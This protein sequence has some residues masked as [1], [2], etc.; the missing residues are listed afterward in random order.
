MNIAG[1]IYNILELLCRGA[2]TGKCIEVNGRKAEIGERTL[3]VTAE[4]H[5]MF[6]AVENDIST[7]K[8]RRGDADS[9]NY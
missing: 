5:R 1:L 3:Y 4:S 7:R 8:S 2:R 9:K 6:V